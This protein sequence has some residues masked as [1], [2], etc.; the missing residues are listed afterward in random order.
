MSPNGNEWDESE[1]VRDPGG[2]FVS[3][4]SRWYIDQRFGEHE[5]QHA[6]EQKAIDLAA[7]TVK[8]WKDDSNEWRGTLSDRDRKYV[9]VNDHNGVAARVDSLERANIVRMET[10]RVTTIAET[11]RKD[12]MERR[13]SRQQWVVGTLFAGATLLVNAFIWFATRH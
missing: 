1:H 8:Q 2:R 9:T 4:G 13:I 6:S 10:E 3:G 5:K 11:R 12:E 7:Q